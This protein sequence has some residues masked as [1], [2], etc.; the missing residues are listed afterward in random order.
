M[1]I[2]WLTN[3][4]VPVSA[5]ASI[6]TANPSTVSVAAVPAPATNPPAPTSYAAA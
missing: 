4:S 5:L 1:A 6:V 3:R 2:S